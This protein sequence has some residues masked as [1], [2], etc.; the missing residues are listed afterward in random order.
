MS[1]L[2]T[3]Y[4]AADAPETEV[5]NRDDPNAS[6]AIFFIKFFIISIKPLY[7]NN[8]FVFL[9]QFTIYMISKKCYTFFTGILK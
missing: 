3:V 7:L 6:A 9:F 5:N 2:F 8:I 4:V 1:P